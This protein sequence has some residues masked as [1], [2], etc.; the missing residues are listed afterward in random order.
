ME[1][2]SNEY[3]YSIKSLFEGEMIWNYCQRFISSISLVVSITYQIWLQQTF[4]TALFSCRS[5]CF[6]S[7][8]HSILD[9]FSVFHHTYETNYL[10][11]KDSTAFKYIWLENNEKLTYVMETSVLKP[12]LSA[13][14]LEKSDVKIV[15]ETDKPNPLHTKS[16]WNR[17]WN[18]FL[19]GQNNQSK[20]EFF[21]G[22]WNLIIDA[23]STMFW[24]HWQFK[25][26]QILINE[27]KEQKIFFSGEMK[28]RPFLMSSYI[29]RHE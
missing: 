16:L 8:I 27:T 9:S 6:C 28:M 21:L 10:S 18:S 7:V 13:L 23:T 26:W 19:M 2:N 24:V 5:R 14:R 12:V 20:V 15:L 25:R 17:Q 29:S 3:E 11:Y 22:D 1:H 4:S